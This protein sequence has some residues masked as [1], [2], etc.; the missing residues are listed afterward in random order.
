MARPFLFERA[1]GMDYAAVS[2]AVRQFGRRLEQDSAVRR[3]M[4]K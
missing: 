2:V 4:E 1:G 3:A